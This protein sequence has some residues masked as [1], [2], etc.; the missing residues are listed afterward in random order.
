M[1]LIFYCFSIN[2]FTQGKS[3]YETTF[4]KMNVIDTFPKDT[5]FEREIYSQM[6]IHPGPNIYS[7]LFAYSV[8]DPGF[9]RGGGANLPGGANIRFCRIFPNTA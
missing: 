9:P 8:P 1:I 6:N 3:G 5:N 4:V 7:C 2:V